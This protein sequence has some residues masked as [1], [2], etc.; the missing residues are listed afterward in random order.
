M[1]RRIHSL[2][3]LVLG[4][5]LAL[6][7]GSGAVLSVQPA[8][9][10]AA[11]PPQSLTIAETAAAITAAAPGTQ[12]ITRSANGV[13]TAQV[14]DAAGRRVLTVDPA[15]GATLPEVAE[16]PVMRAVKSFH[17]SLLL[18][19][20]GRAAVGVMAEAMALVLG[21]GLWLMLRALGGWRRAAA[22][23]HA[24]GA[25][26][27]HA[28]IGRVAL[29]GL[30]VSALTGAWLSA[31]TFGLAPDGSAAVLP[32][33]TAAAGAPLALARMPA[34]DRPLAE[35]R[36]LTLPARPGEMLRL[37]TG[38]GVALVEPATGAVAAFAPVTW[39]GRVWE[40]AYRLHTGHGLWALGLILGTAA[41]AVPVL[42]G[43]GAAI[44]LSR[45][46]GAVRVPGNAPM[47]EAELVILVGSEGGS[48]RGFAASLH[49]ALTA[50]GAR[51]H[52]GDMDAVG[53]MPRAR[54]L[55]LM[56]ATYGDG[57]APASAR[58]F[59][60]R[61]DGLEPLPVAVLG[62]G[63]RAFPRFCAYAETVAAALEARGWP[64]L[65]PLD[66]IDAQSPATF[67]AWGRALGRALALP[68]APEH[69]PALPRLHGLR[70][71]SRRDYGEAVQAP[72]AIL[73]FA[74]RPRW[75][76]GPRFE[77]GD[78]LAVMAPGASAPRFYSLASS[79]RDGF[80]EICVRKV[81]GGVCSTFLHGL[82]PGDRL[83][84]F[85][86]ANPAFRAAPAPLVMISAGCGIGPMAGL[87]RRAA[88]GAERVLYFGLRD[89][90][91]D[92]LY[93]EELGRWQAEG[94]LT[95]LRTAVSRAARGAERGHVQHRLREDAARLRDQIGRGARVLVCGSV[96]M[97]QSVAAELDA[98]LRPA[99]LSVAALKAEGRYVED[100]Y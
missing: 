29:V 22:P 51:V 19:D 97:G 48:T 69:R 6:I 47:A 62:F 56:A 85:T 92:F 43:T 60:D 2:P 72:T 41:L 50:T 31:A 80:V 78:L 73:R 12:A 89:P 14:R 65:L 95:R 40:W 59:L 76:G 11:A 45:R 98:A 44:W 82:R 93:A 79:A 25:K 17:R 87:L 10:R 39:G 1:L 15:S 55:I 38:A 88:P 30:G 18:G 94:R 49:R 3:G 28:R 57:V 24:R 46:R 100:T 26:G 13:V 90:A 61:L 7:A 32:R 91:S 63:D 74:V 99:G 37:E 23:V 86:R 9:E 83:R 16:G 54:A 53:P 35:L 27:W 42:A 75:L 81:P 52:L 58:R 68:I 64:V 8:I 84:G 34:L 5:L 4:L 96:A 36:S 20:G 33:A 77:A 66:R 67:A 21:S 70:L 71:I